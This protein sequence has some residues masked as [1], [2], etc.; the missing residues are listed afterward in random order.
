M[1]HVIIV[2]GGRGTRM[3]SATPKQFLTLAGRPVLMHTIDAFVRA[4]PEVQIVV[5]LPAGEHGTWQ[6]LCREHRFGVPCVVVSGGQTRF[7]SVKHGLD[8]IAAAG[9]GAA[10]IVGVHDGVRPLVAAD[11]I[12]RCY[13][14]A[15]RCGAVVP[16]VPVVETLRCVAPRASHTV[17]RSRYRL[18]QTP[19]TFRLDVLARAYAQPW[20]EAFTDDA[21]VVEAMGHAVTLIDGNRENIKLTTPSDLIVAA[22]LLRS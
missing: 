6:Q 19:Q 20:R 10:D 21:S 18:V 9:G 4:L 15:A 3:G 13:A 14:K 7:H 2:A 5:V 17:E 22:A 1:N 16:V 11:V 8:H 12:R